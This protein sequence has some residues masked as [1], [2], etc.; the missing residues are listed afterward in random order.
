MIAAVNGHAVAGG[1]I[2]ALCADHRVASDDATYGVT[3]LR[4]GAPYPV[5]AMMVVKEELDP[6]AARRLVLGADLIDPATAAAWG[7]VDELTK[8]AAVL[9]RAL[10]VARDYAGLPRRTYEIVKDQLRGDALR[11]MLAE[12]EADPLAGGWF[13]DETPGAARAVIERD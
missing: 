3:E 4:V 1:L 7:V 13:S 12:S 6:A 9:D 5:A 2:L 8:P 11:R 10:E